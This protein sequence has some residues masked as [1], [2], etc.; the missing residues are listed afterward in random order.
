MK[1]TL[2]T[3]LM[4]I[5]LMPASLLYA[6]I[7]DVIDMGSRDIGNC[8]P[9]MCND[10]QPST[11][12]IQ[13][14]EAYHFPFSY[15]IFISSISYSPVHL[16]RQNILLGGTYDIYWGYSA[17]G[18]ELGKNLDANYKYPRSYLGRFS[19]QSGGSPLNSI[20]LLAFGVNY[21]PGLGDLLIEYDVF[22]QDY[23]PN[24]SGNLYMWADDKGTQVKRAYCLAS[25]DC[26]SA[27]TGALVTT[28][29]Y[30]KRP[31]QTAGED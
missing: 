14:Q 23:L 11:G 5:L 1:M 29:R 12:G 3:T 2:K 7:I 25:G 13:Y 19:I 9:F 20:F 21:N 6:Q 26:T 22:G 15:K 4:L 18:L 28:F 24:G 17:K 30:V 16:D 31:V 8:Y 10:K 27:T